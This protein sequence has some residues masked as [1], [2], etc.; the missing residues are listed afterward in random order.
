MR[1]I[2]SR[3]ARFIPLIR[4]D[5]TFLVRLAPVNELL[6]RSAAAYA[7]VGDALLV[8]RN[9]SRADAGELLDLVLALLV[10]APHSLD[11]A[12]TC[13]KSLVDLVDGSAGVGALLAVSESLRVHTVTNLVE[14]RKYGLLELIERREGLFAVVSSYC[15]ELVALDVK[16]II[17]RTPTLNQ[18]LTL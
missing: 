18:S 13:E 16:E 6:C 2:S 3:T 17:C 4:V 14:L 7:F 10:A 12:V 1:R 11:E 5:F 9:A 15:N 8:H